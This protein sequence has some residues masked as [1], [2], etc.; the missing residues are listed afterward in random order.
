MGIGALVGGVGV[1]VC[2]A[3]GAEKGWGK[4]LAILGAVLIGVLVV[5]ILVLSVATNSPSYSSQ[6]SLVRRV[7]KHEEVLEVEEAR[8]IPRIVVSSPSVA[9]TGEL[10]QQQYQ[11][12]Q[13][14]QGERGE[15]D[16]WPLPA[17]NSYPENGN[18]SRNETETKPK[19]INKYIRMF[20]LLLSILQ[21]AILIS[22]LVFT[23]MVISRGEISEDCVSHQRAS[24]GLGGS[25]S[26]S[27]PLPVR[28]VEVGNE[29]LMNVDVVS[30]GASCFGG[31]GTVASGTVTVVKTVTEVQNQSQSQSQSQETGGAGRAGVATVVVD[32]NTTTTVIVTASASASAL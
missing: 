32:V 15:N 24:G 12:Q 8:T 13:E 5:G 30:C 2:E 26:K 19:D 25:W 6:S 17:S 14:R 4:G 18:G 7:R 31:N 3:S 1:L 9:N 23:C 28:V 16:A 11:P 29:V 27:N 21:L 22:L 20:L 10:Q